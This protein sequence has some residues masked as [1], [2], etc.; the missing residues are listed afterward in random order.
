VKLTKKNRY[1]DETCGAKTAKQASS[2]L[3]EK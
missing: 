3:K 2:Q 1:T